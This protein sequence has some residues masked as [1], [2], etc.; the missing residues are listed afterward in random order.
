MVSEHTLTIS[1]V[2]SDNNAIALVAPA[3]LRLLLSLAFAEVW[4]IP[5]AT[6]IPSYQDKH[7]HTPPPHP[8]LSARQGVPRPIHNEE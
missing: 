1:A 5:I 4:R 8:H 2:W 6:S 7:S 3:P